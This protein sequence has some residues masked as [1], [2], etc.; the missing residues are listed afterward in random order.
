[1]DKK[2]RETTNFFVVI[3]NKKRQVKE[4]LRHVVQ[5]RVFRLT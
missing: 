5:M 3:I 4:K 2:L 1:M